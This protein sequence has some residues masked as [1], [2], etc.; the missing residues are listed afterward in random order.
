MCSSTSTL[1]LFK[2]KKL[3]SK[4]GGIGHQI[5]SFVICEGLGPSGGTVSQFLA[6]PAEASA[7]RNKSARAAS[8]HLL[9]SF[10]KCDLDS[11]YIYCA[12]RT[13]CPDPWHFGMDP[14]PRIR[15]LPPTNGS[16]SGSWSCTFCQWPSRHQQKLFSKFFLL[17]TFCR[18]INIY[19][20]LYR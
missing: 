12:V 15:T 16:V 9:R 1:Y 2:N 6:S 10:A 8:T 18:Y 14:D 7:T 19:I 11:W 13:S 20:I 3:L 4:K 17:I 5:F